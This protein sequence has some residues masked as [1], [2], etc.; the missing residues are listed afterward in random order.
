[1][2]E[3]HGERLPSR[4]LWNLEPAE[5]PGL[6]IGV[7]HADTET[8]QVGIAVRFDLD[9]QLNAVV[10][11]QQRRLVLHQRLHEPFGARV[12]NKSRVFTLLGGLPTAP[13]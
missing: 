10:E 3:F 8:C 2:I 9:F 11:G 7:K 12:P 6:V 1:M 13:P 5:L 4:T